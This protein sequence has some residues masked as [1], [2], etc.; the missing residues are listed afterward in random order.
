MAGDP[1]KR[2]L[3]K[4]LKDLKAQGASDEEIHKRWREE[5]AKRREELDAIEHKKELEKEQLKIPYYKRPGYKPQ[6]YI[7]GYFDG[8]TA[9]EE[10][11][12]KYLSNIGDLLPPEQEPIA[13]VDRDW[14]EEEE[15]RPEGSWNELWQEIY[16]CRKEEE[17]EEREGLPSSFGE[18]FWKMHWY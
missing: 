17:E 16:R 1:L 10:R 4:L 3:G 2:D 6:S 8:A 9:A 14:E 15:E 12:L 18:L 13:L 5:Y 7:D 11:I